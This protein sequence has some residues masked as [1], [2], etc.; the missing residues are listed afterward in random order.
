MLQEAI[1]SPYVDY[2]YYSETYGGNKIPQD[3]F[4]AC[5][6]FVNRK[7]FAQIIVGTKRQAADAVIHTIFGRQQN[8]GY[9][10]DMPQMF[11]HFEPV[12]A[13]HHHVQ[14]HQVGRKPA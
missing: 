14:Y 8:D 11:E 3:S 7:G 1:T 5:G 12:H 2:N 9:R 4:D 6:Q 10:R 13:R